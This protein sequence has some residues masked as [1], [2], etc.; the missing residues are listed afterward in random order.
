MEMD[1]TP[2]NSGNSRHPWEIDIVVWYPDK[3]WDGKPGS[4]GRR[5]SVLDISASGCRPVDRYEPNA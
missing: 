2:P 5:R 4:A 1:F 3:P